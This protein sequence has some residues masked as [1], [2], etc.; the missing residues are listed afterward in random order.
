M[1]EEAIGTMGTQG[2]IEIT[3]AMMKAAKDA[4]TQYQT[5]VAAAFANLADTVEGIQSSFSGSAA[6]GFNT[7]YTER[8]NEML[9]ENG[10]LSKLLKSLYDICDSAQKQ[11]PGDEGTDEALAK[12]NNPSS[13]GQSA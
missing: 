7:F 13:G 10:T 8:I 12:I 2:T 3:S 6:A 9:K 11:L 1:A 5:D 4:I